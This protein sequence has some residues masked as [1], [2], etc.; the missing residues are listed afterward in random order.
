MGNGTN[1]DNTPG[2]EN[3]EETH[4]DLKKKYG[5]V[6]TKKLTEEHFQQ[7]F[8]SIYKRNTNISDHYRVSTHLTT[9]KE[10]THGRQASQLLS[11]SDR[12]VS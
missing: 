1:T 6:R 10:V 3:S 8:K 12:R 2:A 7:V 11:E 9:T 4:N 5:S